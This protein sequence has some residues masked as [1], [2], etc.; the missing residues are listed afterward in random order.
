[1]VILL[2]NKRYR[3]NRRKYLA[4]ELNTTRMRT[5]ERLAVQE[6]IDYLASGL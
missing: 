3:N 2:G 4:C 6:L 1:M 5:G